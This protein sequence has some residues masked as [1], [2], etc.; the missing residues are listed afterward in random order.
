[1]APVESAGR[2]EQ[3]ED[4]ERRDRPPVRRV[5][6]GGVR[7]R[8]RAPDESAADR[9]RERPESEE[10]RESGG[11][12]GGRRPLE[13]TAAGDDPDGAD[14]HEVERAGLDQRGPE[15]GRERDVA[16]AVV[17]VRTERRRDGE[18]GRQYERERREESRRESHGRGTPRRRIKRGDGSGAP[19]VADGREHRPDGR[20]LQL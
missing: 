16:A 15:A 1:M 9:Q 6:E 18:S 8:A 19:F 13:R 3:T 2:D 10:R 4:G 5:A 17:Q 11:R 7:V 20:C 14:A 12:E